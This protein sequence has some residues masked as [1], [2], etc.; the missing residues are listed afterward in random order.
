M[1]EA[2]PTND[3]AAASPQTPTG[4]DARPL[5][6][7]LDL[8]TH[9][10]IRSGVLQRTVGWVRAVDGVSFDIAKGET[11]GLV[12]ESGCGKTTV[13][14]S[15]LRL[16]PAT[17]GAV[18]FDDTLVFNARGSALKGLR[19]QMQIIFQDP[20][21]SLNPRMRVASIV[22]EPLTVHGLVED[23]DELRERVETLLERCGMPRAAADRYPHEFSGGQ[24]QRIGIARALA[25]EPRFIVCDEPTSALDV[26]IQAQIIN[27]LTD[28]QAEFGLSY[29]FISH[30]MA[31]IQHVCRNIA[32]MYQGKIVE[33]GP[34]ERVLG[35]P[36][37]DYTRSLLSA[38]PEPDPRRKRSRVVFAGGA[39]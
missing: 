37:H 11:L 38:V 28:L 32:V 8:H 18:I 1:P 9:F 13:G 4:D 22:G 21:G 7:V 27:L 12:G 29:L 14:R 36:R 19:R 30:D 6:S 3:P 35:D 26:S 17:S 16:I 23:R 2:Q 33:M 39:T 15:I 10:P 5:L 20:A 24:R 31:V 34:R 25:L